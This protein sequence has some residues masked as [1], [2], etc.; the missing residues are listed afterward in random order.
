[1]NSSENN[2]KKILWVFLSVFLF[3]NLCIGI[4][5]VFLI[6]EVFAEKSLNYVLLKI[7][8]ELGIAL[9][10]ASVVGLI[11]ENWL[12][13]ERIRLFGRYVRRSQEI[14]Q[15]GFDKIY[16]DRQEVFDELFNN[17]I[18]NATK[19]NI[20]I[21]GICVSLFKEAERG[22]G[23]STRKLKDPE[24]LID[25]I[26]T[27]LERGCSIQI[28]FLKRYL[29]EDEHNKYRFNRDG[30]FYLMRERDEDYPPNDLHGKRLKKIANRS[31][32][33]WIEILLKIS[34]SKQKF[35]REKRREMLSKL[36]IREY[37]ALP[38]LSLYI[39]NNDLFVT[40]Y[41]YKRHCS[42]VPAFGISGNESRLFE[43]YSEHFNV[44]WTDQSTTNA[45]NDDFVR[46][47][48]DYPEEIHSIYKK[49]HKEALNNIKRKYNEEDPDYYRDHENTIE[50]ILQLYRDAKSKVIA[51]H[52]VD[53]DRKIIDYIEK[54][55]G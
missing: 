7:I 6:R 1:M 9:V 8:F 49:K 29:N 34:E 54:T 21:M 14:E 27:L 47:L 38:S 55:V 18:P 17:I 48:A 23:R 33:K 37:L 30:D 31:L 50:A 42:S 36:Q 51:Q 11:F 41:L 35:K 45:I 19:G 2:K 28:L 5:Q 44:T 32:G 43:A 39:A 4:S 25:Q 53:V 12:S 22:R 13:Q 16:E 24:L 3:G 52:D 40:P 46:L 20:R 10:I 26:A 15:Y